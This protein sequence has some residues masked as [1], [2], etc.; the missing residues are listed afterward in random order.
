M[1][2]CATKWYT[3]VS[4]NSG[5]LLWAKRGTNLL[6]SVFGSAPLCKTAS[7]GRA[8]PKSCI[9]PYTL[10]P[11]RGAMSPRATTAKC[12]TIPV[13]LRQHFPLYDGFHPLVRLSSEGLQV[14][15]TLSPCATTAAQYLGVGEVY[16]RSLR[17]ER[18]HLQLAATTIHRDLDKVALPKW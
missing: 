5:A 18:Q 14:D 4:I 16:Q 10:P 12:K 13:V 9:H 2:I 15:S 1:G 11:P 17:I 8:S 7:R 6:C 3:K